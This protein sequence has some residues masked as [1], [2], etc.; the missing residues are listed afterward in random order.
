VPPSLIPDDLENGGMTYSKRTSDFRL[1]KTAV[2]PHPNKHDI[3]L[4]KLGEAVP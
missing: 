2:K 1:A 3:Y 4:G